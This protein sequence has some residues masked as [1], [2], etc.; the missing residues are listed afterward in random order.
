MRISEA[1][2]GNYLKATD[3][4]QPRVLSMVTVTVETIGEEKSSKPVLR[5]HGEQRGLVL[6]KVNSME[7]AAWY[8]DDTQGWTGQPVELY[9]TTTFFSGR[10]VPCIRVRRPA[11]QQPVQYQ[12]PAPVQPYMPAQQQMQ[13][14]QPQLVAAPVQAPNVPFD[15]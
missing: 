9:S 7:I 13:A 8:G 1:F 14:P 5:F 15:A 10:Q 4:P 3:L 12:A 2:S 11:M 6:N